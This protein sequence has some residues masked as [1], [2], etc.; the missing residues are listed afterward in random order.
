MRRKITVTKKCNACDA[1]CP[2]CGHSDL[3]CLTYECGI[4][5]LECPECKSIGTGVSIGGAYGNMKTHNKIF[6]DKDT[7]TKAALE[8]ISESL[9]TIVNLLSQSNIQEAN[10]G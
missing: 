10:H 6:E 9:K 7:R 1:P 8:S 4:V 5:S 2:I 3:H